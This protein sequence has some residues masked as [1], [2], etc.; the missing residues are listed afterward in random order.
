MRKGTVEQLKGMYQNAVK[1][2]EECK[3][4]FPKSSYQRG[5]AHGAVIAYQE[6]FENLSAFERVNMKE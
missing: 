6:I 5:Y 2:E 4:E 1:R 3:N